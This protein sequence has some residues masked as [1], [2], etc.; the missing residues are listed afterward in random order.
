V[1][2]SRP[3]AALD[4][5]EPRLTSHSR[6]DRQQFHDSPSYWKERIVTDQH[7]P[8]APGTTRLLERELWT[9][10]RVDED[11]LPVDP[12]ENAEPDIRPDEQ[13]PVLL[14]DENDYP[15]EDEESGEPTQNWDQS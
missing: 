5:L 14:P 8:A 13:R 4:E 12:Q 6:N 10:E 15:P 2:A 9:A 1:V 11:R 3:G 7:T